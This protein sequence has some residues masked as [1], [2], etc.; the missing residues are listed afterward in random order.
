MIRRRANPEIGAVPGFDT[1]GATLGIKKSGRPDFGVVICE[2]PVRAALVSA[3]NA[4]AAAPL[5]LCRKHIRAAA[6]RAIIVNSGIANAGTGRRGERDALEIARCA[7]ELLGCRTEQV[8]VASTGVISEYLPMDRV[9]NGLRTILT[10]FRPNG[11]FAEAIMTTDTVEKKSAVEFTV[12][13]RTFTVAGCAKGS[14]MIEPNMATML[15]FILTD[16]PIARPKLQRLLN[17]AA[18]LSFN[19][20]SVDGCQ[21]TNDCVILMSSGEL[22]DAPRQKK[23]HDLF[24]RALIE[25]C[26][27]LAMKIVGD[28]EGATRT[29]SVEVVGAPGAKA[30]RTVAKAVVNSPLVKCAVHGADPNFGRILAA[31]GACGVRFNPYK[32]KLWI[33][34]DGKKIPLFVNSKP[35]AKS[36]AATR[37]MRKKSVHF[38]IELGAGSG[39]FTAFG[40]DLTA[41]YVSINADYRT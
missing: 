35:G 6:H 5:K 38:K 21:S 40:C 19:A 10:D 20:I 31:A 9:R 18:N 17:E 27:E 14:G 3:A 26:R 1:L 7:A 36:G 2:R 25:V 4:F 34:D 16:A 8:L 29:F 32:F 28:G 12:G 11:R 41:G 22:K 24:R 13:S 39:V 37:A 15:G 33:L 23:F 30:A